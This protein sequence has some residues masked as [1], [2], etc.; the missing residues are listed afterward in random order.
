MTYIS[1]AITGCKDYRNKFEEAQHFLVGRGDT[2]INPCILN[3]ALPSLSYE[4]YMKIDYLL[5]DMCDTIFML[6]G[7]QSSKGANAEI[8]YA[9]SLGKRVEYR[10]H[11]KQFKHTQNF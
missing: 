6:D 5:I 8:A 7:W 10:R 1:G 9:K 4:D 2:L 11:Y 3:D